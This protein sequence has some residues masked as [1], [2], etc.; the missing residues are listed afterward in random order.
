MNNNKYLNCAGLFDT[1]P[2]AYADISGSQEYPD[3]IGRVRLYQIPY[4]VIVV[5]DIGGLPTNNE[6][7]GSPIFGFHLHEGTACTGNNEDNFAD[8]KGHFNPEGCP[9]PYHAGDFPPLFSADGYAFSA[10]LTNRFEVKDVIGRT[11]IIHSAVDDFTTQPSGNAGKKIAC[12][13][14]VRA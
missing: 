9:H 12:G 1:A 4:G 8:T 11:V 5:A 6:V 7:C 3:I 2:Q 13:V 14:V 10:F